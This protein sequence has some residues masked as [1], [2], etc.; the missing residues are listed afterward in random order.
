V[1]VV[2][3]SIGDGNDTPPA[4]DFNP[5]FTSALA[6]QTYESDGVTGNGGAGAFGGNSRTV[7]DT[8]TAPGAGVGDTN[9]AVAVGAGNLTSVDFG[10]T[11]MLLV[12]TND[13][14]Q[15]S[16][17]QV[18]SNANAIANPIAGS[19]T[20][21]F[22][23]TGAA[24][25][26]IQP[27]TALPTI[28]DA[29]TIDATT[30]AGFGGTPIVELDGTTVGAGGA[31][32]TITAGSNIV[33]GLVINRFSDGIVLDMSDGNVIQGNYIGTDVAGTG[34]RGNSGHGVAI[35]N[36]SDSNAIGGTTA[37]A[38]NRIAF[39]GGDGV[40]VDNSRFNTIR[41][42]S[43]FSNTGLGIDLLPFNGVTFNDGGDSD[44]GANE[45]LNFPIIDNASL[46]I[47]NVAVS[48]EARPGATVELYIS[49]GPAGVNGEGQTFF[50]SFI[51]GA[52]GTPGNDPTA[53]QF[54][55][56]VV[57]IFIV[58]PGDEIT[59]TATDAQGNTSEFAVNV[60]VP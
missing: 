15:G 11:Y 35:L 46:A 5:G 38:G 60:T 20:V 49:D 47:F 4:A 9:V 29:L 52:T 28:T 40:Q 8:A 33:R 3:A 36:G 32:L 18:I 57:N 31:G 21:R 2:S 59:A 19:D 39:N 42:N 58:N 17:R 56:I 43:F 25:Y 7:D 24:T 54:S 30:Q 45:E 22:E 53:V 1:R 23:L 27:L 13:S 48:G 26:T 37:A 12:N 51:V 6:E 34:N 44:N 50:H 10:F 16:L 41:R 55:I 14:G